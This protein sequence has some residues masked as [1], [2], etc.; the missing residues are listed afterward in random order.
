MCKKILAAIA[1]VVV[2][3][4]CSSI[5][6]G[7]ESFS[8][9]GMPQGVVCKTPSQVY[10][11][12]EGGLTPPGSGN[13]GG[14]TVPTPFGQDAH[15]QALVGPMPVLEPA[16]VMRVWI[17]PYVDATSQLHW[18]SFVFAEVT[19]RQWSFG[20]RSVSEIPTLTPLQVEQKTEEIQT[21]AK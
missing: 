13:D 21:G 6:V 17:S 9:P 11:M 14:K 15:F 19:S 3:N 20:E 18:P 1:A 4:G 16:K 10:E 7:N 12:T 5:G 2:L 8:C